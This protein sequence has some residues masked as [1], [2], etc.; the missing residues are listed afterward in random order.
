M[1]LRESFS[2]RRKPTSQFGK[3]AAC[4]KVSE[5]QLVKAVFSRLDE[6]CFTECLKMQVQARFDNWIDKHDLLETSR[7]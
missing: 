1:T 5:K 6:G 2:G 4:A 7:W 3:I